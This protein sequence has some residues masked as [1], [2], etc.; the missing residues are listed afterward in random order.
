M[1]Y[2]SQT[3]VVESSS[4]EKEIVVKL[5]ITLNVNMSTGQVAVGTNP[6]ASV[7]SPVRN[8]CKNE[9]KMPEFIIPKFDTTTELI[10][11]FGENN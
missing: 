11:G 2:F 3:K 10:E 8:D 9:M 7:E 6:I 5:E 4:S 1:A